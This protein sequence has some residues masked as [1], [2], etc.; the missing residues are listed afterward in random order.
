MYASW[1]I[2]VMNNDF[3]TRSGGWAPGM[4]CLY[5]TR[6]L[7]ISD[8]RLESRIR[9]IAENRNELW[10]CQLFR[11]RW[12]RWRCNH[13]DD[14]FNTGYTGSCHVDKFRCKQWRKCR[15]ND[16]ITMVTTGAAS[17]KVG[18][19]MTVGYQ[20]LSYRDKSLKKPPRVH[21]GIW[22]QSQLCCPLRAKF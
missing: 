13:F 16:Y 21:D 11:C 14:I 12:R 9:R 8:V 18:I 22:W 19:R 6:M 17:D 3:R 4:S 7:Y 2:I 10:W 15:Q 5:G 20:R 1:R